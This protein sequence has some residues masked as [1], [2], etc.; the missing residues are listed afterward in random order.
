VTDQSGAVV[1]GATVE[2]T[3]PA[4]GVSRKTITTSAG[5]YSFQDMQLGKYT[6]KVSITGFKTSLVKDVPVTAGVIYTL[7]VQLSIQTTGE[8]V[9]VS[10]SSLALDTTTTTQTTVISEATVQN[11]PLNGRDFTQMIGMAPGFAG[12]ALGGFGSV[13]VTRG[14]QSNWQID[15]SDNNEW[16]KIISAINQGGV[17]NIAGFTLP[18]DSI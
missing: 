1:P 18:I 5:Q 15:G 14:N 4:T 11:I 3:D 7:P 9:E 2:A 10:A 16:C 12:Y 13:N 6:I 17:E 8:T